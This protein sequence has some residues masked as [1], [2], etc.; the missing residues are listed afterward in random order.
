MEYFIGAYK[1]NYANFEGRARRKEYWMFMLFYIIA[2]LVLSF[3]DGLLGM[4]SV[5]TGFGLL[6]G[7]FTLVSL[8]PSIA[9]AARR[10]HD[11]NRSGW[12]QLIVIIP[13]IGAIVL[14]VFYVLDSNPGENRF[15]ANP[16]SFN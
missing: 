3:V 15:G 14:F 5:E 10:L 1:D 4:Y 6:S 8:V 12:W 7:I 2:I 11:T 16:K 9:I 13:L